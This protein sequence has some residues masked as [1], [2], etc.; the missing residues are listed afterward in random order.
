MQGD[1]TFLVSAVRFSPIETTFQLCLPWLNDV[2]NPVISD[3]WK[4][5]LVHCQEISSWGTKR[6][7]LCGTGKVDP[8]DGTSDS[9]KIQWIGLSC[10]CCPVQVLCLLD[11]DIR[12]E[13]EQRQPALVGMDGDAVLVHIVV[14][15]ITTSHCLVA[16]LARWAP[17]TW[18]QLW[19]SDSLFQEVLPNLVWKCVAWYIYIRDPPFC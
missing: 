5:P 1:L 3:P 19:T 18:P 16:V 9:K 12:T 15:L 8:A 13:S 2:V 14:H 17:L 4:N 7:C 10:W 6:R 11:A